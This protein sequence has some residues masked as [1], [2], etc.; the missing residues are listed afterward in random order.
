MKYAAIAATLLVAST[1]LASAHDYDYGY[2]HARPGIDARQAHQNYR[3]NRGLV[4]GQ[5]TWREYA[6]LRREEGRIARHERIARADGYISPA[7]RARLQR[8]LD[9]ASRDI[10]A[11]RHNQRA[12]W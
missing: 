12:G 10:Y 7:E 3:I 9:R 2:G 4:T 6:Y 11:L 5:L 1:S 8:E